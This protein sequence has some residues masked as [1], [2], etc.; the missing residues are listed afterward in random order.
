M[1]TCYKLYSYLGC[2]HLS[3]NFM[4]L[5]GLTFEFVTCIIPVANRNIKIFYL[6]YGELRAC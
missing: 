1:M 2:M 3:I 4:W 5:L 6:F